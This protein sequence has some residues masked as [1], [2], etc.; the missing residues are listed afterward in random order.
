MP[1]ESFFGQSTDAQSTD[2]G[3]EAVQGGAH[4]SGRTRTQGGEV[5]SGFGAFVW[6]TVA[7][8]LVLALCCLAAQRSRRRNADD[9]KE[10]ALADFAV[11][12]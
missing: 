11:A 6:K 12:S 9:S 3:A 4:D 8:S 2:A 7:V 5:E 1:S 10:F